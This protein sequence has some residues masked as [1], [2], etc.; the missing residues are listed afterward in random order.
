MARVLLV[1]DSKVQ[2]HVAKIV[3]QGAGHTVEHVTTAEAALKACYED[4]PAIV[5]QDQHLAEM[6]GLEVCRR[7]KSD[8]ALA[9]IPVL[10]LTAGNR[11]RDH[12]GALDSGADAFL[13]K[14]SPSNELLAVIARLVESAANLRSIDVGD[15]S[16][17]RSQLT[18]ILAI[19]DSPTF[20]KMLSKRLTEAG[21]EVTCASSGSAGLAILYTQ[22]F[23]VAIVDVVM[24]EMDGFEVCTAARR[25]AV[26]N[27]ILLGLL[28]LTGSDRKDVLVEALE[29]GA[30]D[31]A[32]KLQD[33]DVILAHTTALARRI[34]RAKQVRALN[35]RALEQQAAEAATKA[36]SEFLANMSHEI[37]TPM[38]GIIGMAELLANTKLDV[39][40]SEYLRRIQQS[41]DALLRLLNDILDFSKIEAGKLELEEVEFGLR[42]CV[43]QTGQILAIRAAEKQLEIAC[44]IAPDLPDTLLGDPGRLQQI[45]VNLAGNAIK[46]TNDGEV[47]IEVTQH[48]REGKTICLHFAIKG[49]GIGIPE[50]KQARIFEAFS[51]AD[52]STTR[53]FGGTGLALAIS[54]QLVEMMKGRIWLESE[55]GVGTTFHFTAEFQVYVHDT[56]TP[57]SSDVNRSGP[58]PN[59]LLAEDDVLDFDAAQARIPGGTEAVKRMA[60]LL[61]EECPKMLQ[62]LHEGLAD[63]DVTRFQRG[64]H[65]L[66]G[67]AD[68]FSAHRVRAVAEQLETMGRQGEL[69]E[70]VNEV[71]ANLETEAAR[72][73]EAIRSRIAE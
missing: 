6:S 12:I 44:R 25:W 43:G 1:E 7:I 11:E 30:D 21:F 17:D 34:A 23:D 19:D 72:L 15:L 2:A 71:L 50:D 51:Q 40:Q 29:A 41:A 49:T 54:S 61:L 27:D 24:A 3:L 4:P 22:P 62:E 63:G 20:L 37:R 57:D 14:D 45:I 26:D 16:S 56:L 33:V 69:G 10:V 38:N 42:D 67:A 9:A 36:K 70:C 73:T 32:T 58:Q 60:R 66:K 8:I 5:L 64:A 52:A 48:A 55:G 13:P 53:Q 46:F 59:I 35:K 47:V 65:T 68:I 18:R 31:Y 39:D 28:V